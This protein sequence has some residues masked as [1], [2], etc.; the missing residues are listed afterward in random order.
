MGLG[1]LQG[2]AAHG[3][4]LSHNA[5]GNLFR[6]DSSDFQAHGGV[7]PLKLRPLRSLPAPSV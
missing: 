4:H 2:A 6:S 3:N 7:Y 5:D 1:I